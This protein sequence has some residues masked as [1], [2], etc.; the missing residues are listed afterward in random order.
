MHLGCPACAG[1][2]VH[3]A[4]LRSPD[5]P[6]CGLPTQNFSAAQRGVRRV[7]LTHGWSQGFFMMYM[8]ALPSFV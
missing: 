7:T 5:A 2:V 6:E 3:D 8:K 4:D 1:S